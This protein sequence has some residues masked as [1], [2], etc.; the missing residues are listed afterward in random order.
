MAVSFTKEQLTALKAALAKGVKTVSYDG[1]SVTYQSAQEM[2]ETIAMIEREL[3]GRSTRSNYP[4]FER[5]T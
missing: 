4:T 5:G 2:R 1:R 3:Q